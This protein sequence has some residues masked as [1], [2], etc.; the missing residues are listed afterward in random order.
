MNA[1]EFNKLAV[2]LMMNELGPLGFKKSRSTVSIYT[3]PKMMTVYKHTFRGT[4]LGYYLAVTY[5]FMHN[6]K[7]EKS[8]AIPPPYIE[9]YPTSISVFR[10]FEQY[11]QHDHISDFECGLH[12]FSWDEGLSTS[13]AVGNLF[14]ERSLGPHVM[15][16]H[17]NA[18]QFISETIADVKS[19]GM[20]FLDQITPELSLEFLDRHFSKEWSLVESLQDDLRNHL[21]G[22][23]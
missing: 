14:A 1:K 12:S 3:P 21:A 6:V 9:N 4:F 7:I 19:K 23:L 13:K 18:S 22:D 16:S 20:L 17:S 15:D 11:E 5:D 2:S 8:K 10:L